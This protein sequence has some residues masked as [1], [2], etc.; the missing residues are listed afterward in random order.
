MANKGRFLLDTQVFIW[1]MEKSRKLSQNWFRLLTVTEADNQVFLS[2]ASVWEM[3]IKQKKKKLRLPTK[4]ELGIRQ[5]GFGLLPIELA[6]V[7]A[8][9]KLPLYHQDPFDRILIA[10]AQVENLTLISSD[11][12]MARYKVKLLS[13]L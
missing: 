1:W 10:Q 5:S 11:K 8:V 13:N 3:V 2:M 4:I 12:K 9:A 6:H 7:L